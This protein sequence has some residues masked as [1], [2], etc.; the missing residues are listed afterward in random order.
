MQILSLI[1]IFL[2]IM[3][4]LLNVLAPLWNFLW[5]RL[6]GRGGEREKEVRK[7][8]EL[9]HLTNREQNHKTMDSKTVI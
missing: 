8:E 4:T 9:E 5:G 7:C 1:F 3:Q 2:Y 6:K